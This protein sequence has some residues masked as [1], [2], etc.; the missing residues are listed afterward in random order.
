MLVPGVLDRIEALVVEHGRGPGRA[1][2]D[3]IEQARA[4]YRSR[5][6]P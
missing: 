4:L 1:L 3:L 6:S 5:I 2:F